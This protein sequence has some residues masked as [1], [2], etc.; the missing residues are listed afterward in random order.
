MSEKK[1]VST[2]DIELHWALLSLVDSEKTV[3]PTTKLLRLTRIRKTAQHL[4]TER[5]RLVTRMLPL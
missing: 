3:M 5:L 2:F 1:P 4:I